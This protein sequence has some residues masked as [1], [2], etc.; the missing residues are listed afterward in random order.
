[1]SKPLLILQTDM[2]GFDQLRQQ[3]QQKTKES[4]RNTSMETARTLVPL[5]EPASS[6]TT[7]AWSSKRSSL[8]LVGFDVCE[9]SEKI[10]SV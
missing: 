5:N 8:S 9:V 7:A 4:S 1:M 3:Q 2:D 6:N 10:T